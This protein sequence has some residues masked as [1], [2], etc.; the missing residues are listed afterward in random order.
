MARLV[1][2]FIL[3]PV[4]ELALLIEIGKRMGLLPTLTLIVV[5]G[6]VGAALARQQG[7]EVL[8]RLRSELGG[9]TLPTDALVDGALVLMAGA[10]LLTPGVLTDLFGFLCL[11]PATRRVIRAG[12]KR[13]LGT[14]AA[15]GNFR[16]TPPSGGPS[17]GTSSPGMKDGMKN[18][19]PEEERE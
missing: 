9:G 8:E 2:L 13:W 12:L 10:V 7:L 16:F 3:I 11:I 17:V 4:I 18:V 15:K 14:F 5:T 1:L 6:I 19:T